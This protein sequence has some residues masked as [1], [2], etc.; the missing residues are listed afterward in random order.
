[1]KP[2]RVYTDVTTTGAIH[3]TTGEYTKD[4]SCCARR[5][6]TYGNWLDAL[7]RR[8]RP[9]DNVEPFDEADAVLWVA[10]GIVK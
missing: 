8:R 3:Y 4:G 9:V 2:S 5:C 7:Y 1:M 10:Q 6:A